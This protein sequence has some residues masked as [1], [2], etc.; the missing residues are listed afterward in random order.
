MV[1]TVSKVETHFSFIRLGVFGHQTGSPKFNLLNSS[2]SPKSNPYV[3]GGRNVVIR[4]FA[5]LSSTFGRIKNNTKPPP[6]MHPSLPDLSLPARFPT[7]V[8]HFSFEPSPKT[9]WRPPHLRHGTLSPSQHTS[10][11]TA[12]EKF[13]AHHPNLRPDPLPRVCVGPLPPSRGRSRAPPVTPPK[14]RRNI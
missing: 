10:P 14:P 12:K 4:L 1:K 11:W 9:G 6:M 8:E 5:M 2:G 13:P 7:I 3:C